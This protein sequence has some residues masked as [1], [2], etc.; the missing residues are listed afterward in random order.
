MP[1]HNAPFRSFD[2]YAETYRTVIND[3]VKASGEKYEFFIQL[4]VRMMA[5]R[6]KNHWKEGYVGTLLDYGCGTG[7]TEHYLRQYFPCMSIVGAD[8]SQESIRLANMS[9]LPDVSYEALVESKGALPFDGKKFDLAYSNG[10]FHH[11]QPGA[12]VEALSELYRVLKVGGLLYV[13][14]NNPYNPLTMRAMKANPF[15][16]GM[17]AVKPCEMKAMGEQ[18]GLVHMATW[19]YFFFPSC[20]RYFRK[21]DDYL[22][23]LP[24]GAQYGTCFTRVS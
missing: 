15:D 16:E 20:L 2:T 18:A 3:S 17:V 9:P 12:R 13:F 21:F 10:T 1:A 4:R 19:F 23:W 22:A 14:E 8:A 11:I 7:A 6:V 5:E 24:I